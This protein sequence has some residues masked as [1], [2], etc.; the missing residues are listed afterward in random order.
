[1]SIRCKNGTEHSHESVAESRRCW[2][3]R[4]APVAAPPLPASPPP[5]PVVYVRPVS[6]RQMEY[7]RRYNGDPTYASKLSYDEA[8]KY[9]NQLISDYRSSRRAPAVTDPR[10]DMITAMLDGVPDGYYATAA[11]GEGGHVDFLRVSRPKKGRFNGSVKIQT[12]HSDLWKEALIYWPSGQWSVWKRNAIDIL[13]MVIADNKTCAMRYA[14]EVQSCCMCNKT[15]TDDRSRHYLVGPIC[16]KKDRGIQ[17]CQQVDDVNGGQT[18][19]ELVAF[20]LPTRVW[21]DR[22]LAS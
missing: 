15:L 4:Y 18:Y 8:Y 16:D 13:L 10:L 19:E 12:Q 6:E 14:I 5:P 11:D 9:V 3:G 21:Q 2:Q 1:M 20:G 22:A 7:V 17:L